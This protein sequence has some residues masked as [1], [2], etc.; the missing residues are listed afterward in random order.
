MK[1]NPAFWVLSVLFW[2]SAAFVVPSAHVTDDVLAVNFTGASRVFLTSCLKLDDFD[3]ANDKNL[4]NKIITDV[5]LA[6]PVYGI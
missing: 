6:V 3:F 5:K 1:K 2:L 4:D